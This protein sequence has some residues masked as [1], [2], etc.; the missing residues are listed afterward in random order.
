MF[1]LCNFYVFIINSQRKWTAVGKWNG[2]VAIALAV[3]YAL[4][5]LDSSDSGSCVISMDC[6]ER[7][8]IYFLLSIC[9]SSRGHF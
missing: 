1:L 2:F 6:R 7:C 5:K 3:G 4:Y 9:E 8:Q